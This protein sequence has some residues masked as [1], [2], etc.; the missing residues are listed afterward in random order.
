MPRAIFH[1]IHMIVAAARKVI[2]DRYHPMTI[3]HQAFAQVRPH[4]SGSSRDY[5]EL[6]HIDEAYLLS[7]FYSMCQKKTAARG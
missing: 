1:T 2:V 5:Y 7:P 3:A 4:K 6:L